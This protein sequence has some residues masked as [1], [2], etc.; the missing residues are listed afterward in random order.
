[1]KA[2]PIRNPH[3]STTR[4]QRKTEGF[5]LI[6]V[7]VVILIIVT[8]VGIVIGI[9]QLANNR[10]AEAQAL[11][12]MAKWKTDLERY[13]E[14]YGDYPIDNN[15]HDADGLQLL[16]NQLYPTTDE[17]HDLETRD[18]WGMEYRYRRVSKHRY[19]L[20]SLGMDRKIGSGI[21][22]PTTAPADGDPLANDYRHMGEGDDITIENGRM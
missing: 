7:L 14:K 18:P 12:M 2:H 4:N 22:V 8:L 16:I 17:K 20:G 13:K 6:E 19:Q 21:P 5:T 9:A 11:A 1:M 3:Q 15:L 10:A